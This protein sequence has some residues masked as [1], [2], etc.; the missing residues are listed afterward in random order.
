MR[1]GKMKA[2]NKAL[3]SAFFSFGGKAKP[4]NLKRAKRATATLHFGF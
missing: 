2:G 1:I 3:F 4:C